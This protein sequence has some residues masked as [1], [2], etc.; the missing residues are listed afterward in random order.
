MQRE[1]K[2]NLNLVKK[3]ET[4][5]SKWKNFE[6]KLAIITK[7]KKK[8]FFLFNRLS[9]CFGEIK[10]LNWKIHGCVNF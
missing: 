10:S 3:I 2:I 8:K 4:K 7:I 5:N 1:M 6:K 9:F